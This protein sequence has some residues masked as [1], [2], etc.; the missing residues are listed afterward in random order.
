[1]PPI[2]FGCD[3]SRTW[4]DIHALPEDARSRI[5]NTPSA[6]VAWAADLDPACLVVFEA[7]S[8]CDGPL[9][10]ALSG[11]GIAFARVNPRQ[12]REFARATGILAKTDRV[13]ARVLAEM[14][15][16]RPTPTGCGS[17]TS[18]AAAGSLSTR[19]RPRKSGATTRGSRRS[20]AT[21]RA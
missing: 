13:D 19:A 18:C 17:R 6:V 1:M 12:A 14:G 15:R 4:L 16:R 10:D 2:V 9:I 11:R 7:T 21:S 3:L 8:G 20:C 5:E